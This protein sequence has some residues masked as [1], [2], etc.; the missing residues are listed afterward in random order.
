MA[1][2]QQLDLPFSFLKQFWKTGK[3]RKRV[4][5][6]TA[7]QDNNPWESGDTWGEHCGC[8][9]LLPGE[10]CR[11]SSDSG[12]PGGPWC[13]GRLWHCVPEWS[14]GSDGNA[15]QGKSSRDQR[16]VPKGLQLRTGQPP[17]VGKLLKG[18]TRGTHPGMKNLIIPRASG[19]ACK[20][21][22]P[23]RSG[24]MRSRMKAILSLPGKA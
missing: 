8:L 18:R 9:S 6:D 19:G 21:A 1:W 12:N 3:Y 17:S 7:P 10:F 20:R 22:L 5:S 13:P 11:G 16:R 2:Q 4:F 24:K 23:Q 15:T 14:S